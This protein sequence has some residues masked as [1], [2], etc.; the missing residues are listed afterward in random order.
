M[1]LIYSSFYLAMLY[2]SI[3]II[4]QVVYD[5]LSCWNRVNPPPLPRLAGSVL[6]SLPAFVPSLLA[7]SSVNRMIVLWAEGRV[8]QAGGQPDTQLSLTNRSAAY[9][10]LALFAARAKLSELLKNKAA[11]RVCVNCRRR[12]CWLTRPTQRRD[13]CSWLYFALY[14]YWVAINANANG[15]YYSRAR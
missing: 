11:W 10:S 15:G 6:A 3:S 2:V 13:V 5:D 1:E 12:S 8:G 14:Y 4:F 9:R 7:F